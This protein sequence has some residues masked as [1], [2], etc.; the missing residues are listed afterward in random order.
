MSETTFSMI[1][2]H[3]VQG[4][5]TGAIIAMIEQAGFT[6]KA[7]RMTQLSVAQAGQFYQVHQDRPFYQQMCQNIAAGPVVAMLLEKDNAVA[8]FRKLLG[9]TDPTASAAGTIRHQFGQSIEE[10]AVHGS[11][12]PETAAAEVKFFFGTE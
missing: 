5:Q 2:P 7:L 4:H 6:I 10:N 9:A 8:D 3:A 12:A 1:K 11:D